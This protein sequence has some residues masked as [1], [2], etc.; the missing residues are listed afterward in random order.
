LQKLFWPDSRNQG[1]K[2]CCSES[3][4]RKARK[5]APQKRWRGKG[6]NSDYSKGEDNVKRVQEWQEKIPVTGAGEIMR[7]QII[8]QC[9]SM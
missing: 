1:K 7:C 8:H 9:L 3:D 5:A 6:E 2:K 4:C